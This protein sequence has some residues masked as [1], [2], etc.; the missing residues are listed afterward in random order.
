MCSVVDVIDLFRP[1]W[2]PNCFCPPLHPHQVIRSP[3]AVVSNLTIIGAVLVGAITSNR[4]LMIK[5][6]AAC[7]KHMRKSAA[8]SSV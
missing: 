6:S 2:C 5:L 8:L 7:I 3:R 4:N 1:N